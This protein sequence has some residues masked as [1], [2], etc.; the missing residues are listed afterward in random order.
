[1]QKPL[2][3]LWN[4]DPKSKVFAPKSRVFALLGAKALDFGAKA[5]DFF[6][7]L[8]KNLVKF[9]VGQVLSS[10]GAVPLD[11]LRL[12]RGRDVEV[13][14]QRQLQRAWVRAALGSSARRCSVDGMN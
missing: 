8:A 14:V 4:L 7:F 9:Q 6:D 11:R 3:I 12:P 1:M 10:I 13:R 2:E 5:L